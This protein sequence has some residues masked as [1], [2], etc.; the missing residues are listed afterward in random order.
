MSTVPP[1]LVFPTLLHRLPDTLDVLALVILVQIAC[2]HVGRRAGVRI[3]EQAIVSSTVRSD[4]RRLRPLRGNPNPPKG[5][6]SFNVPLDTSQDRGDIV[7]GAPP[8]L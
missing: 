1:I 7:R 2:L 8:V 5:R 3:I 6:D 4:Y